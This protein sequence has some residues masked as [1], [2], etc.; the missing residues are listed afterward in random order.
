MHKFYEKVRRKLDTQLMSG[1]S[2][3]HI[4]EASKIHRNACFEDHEDCI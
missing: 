1:S 4:L 3:H 2:L